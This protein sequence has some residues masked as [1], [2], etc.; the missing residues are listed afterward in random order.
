MAA[1]SAGLCSIAPAGGKSGLVACEGVLGLQEPVSRPWLLHQPAGKFPPWLKL[2][3]KTS[4][5]DE[6]YLD[7]TNPGQQPHLAPDAD[8][9]GQYWEARPEMGCKTLEG[10]AMARCLL[11]YKLH[12]MWAGPERVLTA[13]GDKVELKP[14]GEGDCQVWEILLENGSPWMPQEEATPELVECDWGHPEEEGEPE[15]ISCDFG[16]P[17]VEGE[18]Q[19]ISCD[20][21]RPEVEVLEP[22][23][24]EPEMMIC[25][26]LA[27]ASAGGPT[28]LLEQLR[29]EIQARAQG[30]GWNG[31]FTHWEPVSNRTQV[32]AGTNH[33][34]KVRVKEDVYAHVKIYE[35][36]PG[37]GPPQLTSVELPKSREDAL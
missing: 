4:G 12:S 37:Q 34:C 30:Q 21:G 32:V 33:F 2:S 24:A 27:P 18:P 1:G 31:I 11:G 10:G 23:A 19:L 29:E 16:H 13:V 25:G 8:V 22:E 7:L 6:M 3:V 35:P 36:L 9:S 14:Q 26:G 17:E 5:S 15:M 28:A 20:F